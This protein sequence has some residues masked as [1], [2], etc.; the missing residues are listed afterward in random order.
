VLEP[1]GAVGAV[2]IP[3][4]EGDAMG[5]LKAISDVFTVMLAVLDATEVG[6]VPIVVELTPPTLFTVGKSAVPPKSLVNFSLPL[7]VASASGVIVPP[8]I[9]ETNS[10]VA[11]CVVLVP[12]AAVG[13]V[14]MPV[15]EGD[16]IVALKA[17][18][19]VFDVILTVLDKIL[20]S[21]NDSAF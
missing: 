2:G 11:N 10:V 18:S 8:K 14:G 3:V 21:N 17:I 4:N 6:N 9:V 20:V 16:A 19:D 13:A 15:N 7:V 12:A 1:A 5:A